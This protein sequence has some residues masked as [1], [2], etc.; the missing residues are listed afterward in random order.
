[1]HGTAKHGEKACKLIGLKNN[2]LFMAGYNVF[3]VW[4]MEPLYEQR[5]LTK[6]KQ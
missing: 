5:C 1:M 4:A 3:V 6:L 2:P